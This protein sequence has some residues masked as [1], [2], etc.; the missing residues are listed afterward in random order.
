MKTLIF[1]LVLT[2][3]VLFWVLHGRAWLKSRSW[4][5]SQALFAWLDP[6][7]LALWKKSETILFARFKI[8]TGVLL[9]F[10]TSIGQLDLSPLIFLFPERWQNSARTLVQFVP[11]SIT[12]LGVVDEYLRRSTTKPLEVVAIPDAAPPDVKAA[13][14]QV[15]ATN[16]AAVAKVQEAKAEGSV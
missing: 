1:V 3:I 12:L 4:G 16:A 13:A 8:M 6:I 10:L 14:A 11:L 15:D 7:E 2:L 9:T 5:W